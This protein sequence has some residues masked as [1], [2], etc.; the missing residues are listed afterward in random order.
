M[1]EHLSA[2]PRERGLICVFRFSRNMQMDLMIR[3][4]GSFLS[5]I[6]FAASVMSE[7]PTAGRIFPKVK[8]SRKM[9]GRGVDQVNKISSWQGRDAEPR[10]T[11]VVTV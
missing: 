3:I 4:T 7:A 6:S 11:C 2:S 10:Q 5:L 1:C 8:S 9:F